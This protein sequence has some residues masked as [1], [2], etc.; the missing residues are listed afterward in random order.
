ME[1]WSFREFLCIVYDY[2][3]D[4]VKIL[5]LFKF[6]VLLRLKFFEGMRFMEEVKYGVY[7]GKR[8]F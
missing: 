6:E 1:F 2:I 5:E 7:F 8:K 4:R 3:V